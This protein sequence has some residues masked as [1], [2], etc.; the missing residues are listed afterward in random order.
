MSSLVD[1]VL[2][3]TEGTRGEDG[4]RLGVLRPLVY[5]AL[6]ANKLSSKEIS[7]YL[8]LPLCPVLRN[9]FIISLLT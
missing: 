7:P 2:R 6:S 8:L 1:D 5:R 9:I 3:R 4:E